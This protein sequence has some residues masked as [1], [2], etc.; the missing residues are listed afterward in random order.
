MP[1]T[2]VEP[3]A[4]PR[5]VVQP[6]ATPKQ[7]TD[8]DGLEK[9]YGAER[10]ISITDNTLYRAKTKVGRAKDLYDGITKVPTL[11]NAVPILNQYKSFMLGMKALP[12]VGDLA[13]NVATAIP[14]ASMVLKTVPVLAR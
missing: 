9:A 1:R 6:K 2:P 5:Q 10:D 14:N 11:W 13:R 8:K 4:V 3:K 7:L 12:Y